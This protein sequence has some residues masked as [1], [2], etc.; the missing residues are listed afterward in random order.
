MDPRQALGVLITDINQI[1]V[2]DK[3]LLDGENQSVVRVIKIGNELTDSVF[4]VKPE[5]DVTQEQQ[6]T[7][8]WPSDLLTNRIYRF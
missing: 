5:H 8:L 1:S 4:Y 6:P 7:P 2:M 3:L